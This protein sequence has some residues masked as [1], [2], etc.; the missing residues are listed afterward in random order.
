MWSDLIAIITGDYENPMGK[1]N[2]VDIY[3]IGEN[4][5]HVIK[6]RVNMRSYNTRFQD[7]E[8]IY[9]LSQGKIQLQS[10]S[11]EIFY[12]NIRLRPIDEIPA[13]FR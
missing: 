13:K 9:P 4:S 5:V 2:T 1:W 12:R 8:G 10:E 6:G 3:T 7:K 11:A